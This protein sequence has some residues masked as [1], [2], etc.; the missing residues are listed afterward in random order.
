MDVSPYAVS[1]FQHYAKL[2]AARAEITLH[3]MTNRLARAR[4]GVR[5]VAIRL[6]AGARYS[7]PELQ[8]VRSD[9]VLV[10]RHDHQVL[11]LTVLRSLQFKVEGERGQKIHLGVAG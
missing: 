1:V 11:H 2:V 10:L 3:R 6:A 4:G 8:R 9:L 7:V 5:K